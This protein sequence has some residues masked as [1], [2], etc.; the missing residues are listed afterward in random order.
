MEASGETI[1]ERDGVVEADELY[2]HGGNENDEVFDVA[3][4][5]LEGHELG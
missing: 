3:S 1:F 4:F 2:E 5:V